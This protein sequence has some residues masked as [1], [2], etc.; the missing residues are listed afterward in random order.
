MSVLPIVSPAHNA[1][2]IALQPVITAIYPFALE[3]GSIDSTTCFLVKKTSLDQ[4]NS[5]LQIPIKIEL[6]RIENES[7]EECLTFDYGE[8]LNSGEKYRS[9]VV[10]SAAAQLSSHSNY[11][12][13]L[14]KDIGKKSVFDVKLNP[15]NTGSKKPLVKGPYSGFTEDEY[16]IEIIIGGSENT[17][18]YKVTRL[19]DNFSI[20][21]LVAKKRFIEIEKN[22]FIKFDTGTYVA[23]DSFTV[24][25]KPLIK[26]NEIYS[27][28][29]TTGDGSYV[30]PDSEES[31]T[32]IGLP[33]NDSTK[34]E[35]NFK[36]MSITPTPNSVM[37]NPLNKIV[38]FTF[39]KNIKPSSVTAEKI[40]V[41]AESTMGSY[42]GSIGYDYSVENNKII[43]T[44][45]DVEIQ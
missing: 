19:S 21:N 39:N 3:E 17:T 30:V 33:I 35:S 25:V 11:S 27:W 41:I 40:K 42:Y 28:D 20:N 6:K 23:G 26:T 29:F 5:T 9:K 13:I 7:D 31:N 38:T 45:H 43:I 8:D 37:N 10:I 36:L 24:K 16:K 18:T 34:P 32:V 4:N 2:G 12:V 44:F 22:V 1:D 14:S 15:A